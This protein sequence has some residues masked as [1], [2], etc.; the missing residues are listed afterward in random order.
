[1]G[2]LG[3]GLLCSFLSYR[4]LCGL[5]SGGLLSYGFLCSFLGCWFLC[6]FLGCWFLCSFLCWLLGLLNYLLC[7]LLSFLNFL[8]LLD[9]CK[10]EGSLYWEDGLGS[11]HLPDGELD[12]SGGFLLISNFVV[13]Q[14]SLEDGLA[15]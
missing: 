3:S 8:D 7:W 1:M 12:T 9:L 15:R 11:Q 4:L 5:L 2:F 13:G 10:L 6:G 14:N